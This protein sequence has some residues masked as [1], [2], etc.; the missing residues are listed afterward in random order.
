M[1]AC[2]RPGVQRCRADGSRYCDAPAG[3][4]S[5]EVC[6]GVDDDRDGAVDEGGAALAGAPCA[7]GLGPCR[8][9]GLFR[10]ATGRAVCDAV[11]GARAAEACDGVDNDCNGYVDDDLPRVGATC[12]VE[13]P[14]CVRHGNLMCVRGVGPSCETQAGRHPD[15]FYELAEVCNG[16]DDDCNGL[17]DEI[18]ERQPDGMWRPCPR[19]P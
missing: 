3:T 19:V 11:A 9:E 18:P 4:P 6:N 10:C 5:P 13:H 15:D 2:V 8:R 14:W 16:R 1:G 12:V 17:V 7:A